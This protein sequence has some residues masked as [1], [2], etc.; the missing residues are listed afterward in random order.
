MDFQISPVLFLISLKVQGHTVPHWKALRYGKNGSRGLSCDSTFSICQDILKI[1]NLLHKQGLVET[2]L[3]RTVYPYLELIM[4]FVKVSLQSVKM[5]DNT[6]MSV[7]SIN[8]FSKSKR[9]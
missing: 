9:K 1:E 3:L 4:T 6:N 8:F 7:I 5:I 2:Q